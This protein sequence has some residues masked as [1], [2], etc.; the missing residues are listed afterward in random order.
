MAISAYASLKSLRM[1]DLSQ[2][3]ASGDVAL[4]VAVAGLLRLEVRLQIR[5]SPCA[6]LADGHAVLARGRAWTLHG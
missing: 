6:A 5:V 4:A 1:W 2:L 3:S